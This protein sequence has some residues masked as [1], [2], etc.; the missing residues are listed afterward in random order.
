ASPRLRAPPAPLLRA[1]CALS[2]A[3]AL[4][5]ATCG[6]WSVARAEWLVAREDNP[7][8]VEYEQ[9]IVRGRILDREGAP[10][11]DVEVAPSGLVTRTY[12]VVEA[13]PVVG[14]ASL[15]HGTGGIEAA[16]DGELRGEA[17]RSA[18]EAAW[19]DLLHRPPQ[20]RDVQ[21]SLD[22]GLQRTAQRALVGRQGAVVLL[23]ARTGEV[24]A[25]ASAPT[26]DPAR[27]DEAWDQLREDPAAPLVNRAT[28]GLYQP[29][30]ALETVV[31]AEAVGRG[32][33]YLTDPAQ[34]VTDTVRVNDVE[35]GC[36][37][38]P[39]ELADLAAA[40]RSA[41]P[42]PFAALG[43]QLGEGGLSAAVTRWRLIEPPA[44][45][46][47]TEAGTWS[48]EDLRLEAMGQ[49]SLTLS[50]LGMAQVA[51]ALAND[52]AIPPLHLVLRVEEPGDGWREP[53]PPGEPR[54]VVPPEM[55]RALL[56]A[57][58]P[59]GPNILG[60]LGT[61]VAGQ[62]RPPHAWFLGVAPAG[63]PRFAVA[64]LLEHPADPRRAAEV[65]RALLEATLGE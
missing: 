20:G 35:V 23:D 61:A 19:A 51:A 29:G 1:A 53:E 28:Q 33:A 5:A 8:R 13:A 15:R 30:A 3:L 26:F 46:I 42:G 47:P 18:W 14:Y 10:L 43:E 39:P 21:L 24:L 41:C 27:L 6:Y 55:A 25:M 37:E 34:G 40:Y 60:H 48:P 58:S 2:L 49:G 54:S 38:E 17:G 56:T 32:L 31:L 45:E 64:V 4:L 52:G 7:R 59:Y 57:W 50:P 36:L 11:A 62:D 65:G 44:L 12:P 22:A 16:F 9:R 63:S